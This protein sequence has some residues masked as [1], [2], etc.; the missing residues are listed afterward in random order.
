LPHD[1]VA[2]EDVLTF[3]AIALFARTPAVRVP[4]PA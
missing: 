3:D 4:A 1:P 2:V